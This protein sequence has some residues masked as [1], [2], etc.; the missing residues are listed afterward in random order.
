MLWA[1]L[2]WWDSIPMRET[3]NQNGIQYR[4]MRRMYDFKQIGT[5]GQ[6]VADNWSVLHC[7]DKDGFETPLD[8]LVGID[9]YLCS[10]RVGIQ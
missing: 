3:F 4:L 2:I 8:I 6:G 9:I 5:N 7:F 1:L 10:L